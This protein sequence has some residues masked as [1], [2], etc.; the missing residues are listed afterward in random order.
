L[1]ENVTKKRFEEQRN[2]TRERQRGSARHLALWRHPTRKAS[3][4]ARKKAVQQ[5]AV[6]VGPACLQ[7]RDARRSWAPQHK[8][9]PRLRKFAR[10]GSAEELD[11]DD[12]IHSTAANAG[13][14]SRW[15]PSATTTSKCC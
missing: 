4:S 7:D 9:A 15:C 8:V 10:L 12:T 5:S 14:T 6:K 1:M 13:W 3:A 2:A 11:L